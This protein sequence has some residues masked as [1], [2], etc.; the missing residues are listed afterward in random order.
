LAAFVE[1]SRNQRHDCLLGEMSI[2]LE[3]DQAD[4]GTSIRNR[5]AGVCTDADNN[6][7]CRTN[8]P[9]KNL[10][11]MSDKRMGRILS[12]LLSEVNVLPAEKR[13]LRKNL[14]SA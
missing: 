12:V 14:K 4:A 8:L 5:H 3:Q 13:T 2:D 1:V 9:K 6:S 10:F 7:E 11:Q